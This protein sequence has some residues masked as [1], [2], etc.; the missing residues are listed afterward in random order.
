MGEEAIGLSLGTP[1]NNSPLVE[2]QRNSPPTNASAMNR[3]SGVSA[4]LSAVSDK[5]HS[6]FP[7]R[8]T[9][10]RPPSV[11]EYAANVFP[12]ALATAPRMTPM[13]ASFTCHNCFPL[14]ARHAVATQS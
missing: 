12:S 10:K 2:Y 4:A 13:V 1:H 14:V 9:K 6:T 8:T 11:S 7:S 3:P 5:V